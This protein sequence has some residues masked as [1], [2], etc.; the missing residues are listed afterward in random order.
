MAIPLAVSPGTLTPGVYL[1]VDLLAGAASPSTGLLRIALMGSKSAAGDLTPDTEVRA[2]GGAD[3]AATAF[4]VGTPAHLAAKL[5]YG[6]FAAAVIDFIA[7]IAGTGLAT[8]DIT[9]SG[10]PTGNNVTLWDVMGREFEVA[11]LLGET[12]EDV[13]DKAIDAIN[14]RTD[15][16][17]TTAADGG[18]GIVT[19]NAKTAGNE[20]ND[21]KV[22]V[23]LQNPA[24]GTEAVAGALVPTP[25]AGGA[26]DP[27]YT[28]A[29]AATSGKEYAAIL[30]CLSNTDVG[31]VGTKNNF[32][33]VIDH[34]NLL[35]TGLDAK[36]Q[37][38]W[39][40][41][42]SSIAIAVPATSNANGAQNDPTGELI[43]CVNGRG[44]PAELG[45]REVGGWVAATSLDP[46]ANRIG[47][48]MSEYIGSADVDGDRPSPAESE[49]ALG[50]GVSLISYTAQGLEI[51]M[52]AIT[53][54]SQ[55]AT[56][57]P[58]R[59]LLDIQNVS[60]TYIV[61][62]DLREALPQEFPNAK[63]VKD[64]PAGEDPP[65]KGVIEERDVKAFLISR[66]RFW[67]GEGVITQSSLDTA[68]ST[69]TLIVQVNASDPS[70]VD[71]VLP[72]SIVPPLAKFGVVVQRVPN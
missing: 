66:L 11:W 4:G 63:I 42:T 15:D 52:R 48:D 32:S 31:N 6:Q 70:Q 64:T 65:P 69:G 40:G 22:K 13:K 58:D 55:T 47:E 26:T 23:T 60:A 3:T 54:H 34:I 24:T 44:L 53:T 29:L 49:T 57:A 50:N 45:G 41:M 72:F 21:V 62:R 20:G 38:A 25:L 37:Q 36:L 35:N 19:I 5:L 7:P 51:L 10:V 46:A 12:F 8:L 33:R 27:D 30:P 39:V 14:S 71:I 18:V 2:G 43:L 61:A 17:F 59:R 67:Q 1:I 56:G 9:L 28:N 68:V 16:L